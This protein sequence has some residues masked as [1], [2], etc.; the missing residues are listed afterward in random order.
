VITVADSGSRY[1][2]REPGWDGSSKAHSSSLDCVN[3]TPHGLTL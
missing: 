1:Y 3:L 2:G